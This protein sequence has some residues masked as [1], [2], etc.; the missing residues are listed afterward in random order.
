VAAGERWRGE[1]DGEAEAMAKLRD[2]LRVRGDQ[3][4]V[5]LR[6]GA[7]G[8]DDPGEQSLPA[9]SRNTLRGRRVEASRAGMTPSVRRGGV[10][11][12]CSKAMQRVPGDRITR[13]G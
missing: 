7:R 9:T 10:I 13:I 3:H 8:L 12:W 6:T 2:L 5:E 11:G 1:L 4:L